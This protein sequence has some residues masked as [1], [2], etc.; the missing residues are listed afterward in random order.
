MS[1]EKNFGYMGYNYQL[2][3]LSQV[4]SDKQF[5]E[6]VITILDPLYFDDSSCRFVCKL[7]K[8]YFEKYK[9]FPSY[10]VLGNIVKTE[11]K[12]EV[13][14]KYI[15]DVI[16]EIKALDLTDSEYHQ[17]T[18]F[19]FCKQQEL[20]KAI[21]KAEMLLDKGDFE[22]YDE[23]EDYIKKAL[24]FGID[25][26]AAMDV[27]HNIESVMTEDYRETIPTGIKGLDELMKGGLAKGE[28]GIILAPLGC[29][30]TTALTKFA[31]SGYNAGCNVL[32]IFFEDNTK[33][34]Q[35][36]HICCW[37]GIPLTEM[38]EDMG[39]DATIKKQLNELSKNKNKLLLR[40]WSSDTMTITQIKN[41]IKKLHSEGTNIDLVIIDYI[42]CVIPEKTTDDS[43]N[44]EG[45]IM[46]KFEAMCSELNIAGWC[47]T[48]GNR[49]SIGSPVVTNDQVGGSIKKLQIGHVVISIA[50]SLAQKESGQAT[51]AIL[52]SRISKD[53]VVF[54][55]CVFDNEKM[56]ISTD[57]AETFLGFEENRN[58]RQRQR[59]GE[60]HQRLR[61]NAAANQQQPR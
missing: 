49:G 58:D 5:A 59:A 30:K 34:I 2:K 26:D 32:Q 31:N 22:H 17:E 39:K 13:Q 60:V 14:C 36:K 15:L 53:G 29:G 37:T 18:S 50:K 16:G 12:T 54:E 25:R 33:E 46:R 8:E 47:G 1:E 57:T 38:N 21:K 3:V 19:K 48:Q 20:K 23:I 10:D 27:F 35:R 9:S 51:M 42:D 45:K 24:S 41:Y 61:Q 4:M 55:N 56:K 40:R 28:I 44:D 6:S 11:I 52:K 7:I 43:Y